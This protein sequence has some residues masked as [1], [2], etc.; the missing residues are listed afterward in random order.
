MPLTFP[1]LTLPPPQKPIVNV[2]FPSYPP[3][4]SNTALYLGPNGSLGTTAAKDEA[5]ASYRAEVNPKDEASFAEE[6]TFRHKFATP[7]WLVGYSWIAL[8][9]SSDQ[10]DIDVFVQL[11]KQDA[12][13]KALQCMNV[14]LNELIPAVKDASE[15]ADSCFLKYHGP[16]GVLRATHAGT[17]VSQ[18]NA[19]PEYRNDSQE[20]IKPGT[21]VRLEIPIWLT[22]ISFE[23][24]EYLAIKVSGHYMGF[25]EFEPLNGASHRNKGKPTIYFGGKYDNH[26]VVPLIDPISV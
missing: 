2:K 22:G 26:L 19:W 8:H 23:A 6:I 14:P 21:V 3:P 20:K 9:V 17:K 25:M 18:P 1:E 13:G 10:D 7:T 4:T 11:Q 24:G 12:S 15:V 5:S 16:S